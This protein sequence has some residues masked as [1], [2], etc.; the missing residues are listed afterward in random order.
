MCHLSVQSSS[1]EAQGSCNV[2]CSTQASF[3]VAQNS[4]D[5]CHVEAQN[6]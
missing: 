3:K 2:S 4:Y 6:S 1:E 5:I